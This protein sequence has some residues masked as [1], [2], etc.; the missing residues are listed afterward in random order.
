MSPPMSRSR[1]SAAANYDGPMTRS[2]SAAAAN[3]SRPMTR[4]RTAAAANYRSPITRSHILFEDS[5]SA[6]FRKQNTVKRK[7]FSEDSD[8]EKKKKKQATTSI[9]NN[10]IQNKTR[11]LNKV[12]PRKPSTAVYVL[13]M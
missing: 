4:S 12:N 9:N 8:G 10:Q 13:M 1:S 2:R 5:R 11:F 3:Y 6:A 7:S